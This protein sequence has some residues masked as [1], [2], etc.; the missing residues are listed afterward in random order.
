[1]AEECFYCGCEIPKAELLC[2]DGYQ[3]LY[4][5]KKCHD[6]IERDLEITDNRQEGK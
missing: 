1:M 6:D 3:G 5:H 2:I 4:A